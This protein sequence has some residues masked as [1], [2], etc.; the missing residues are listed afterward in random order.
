MTIADIRSAVTVVKTLVL[1]NITTSLPDWY[2]T[3]Q[4]QT[5][6]T[7]LKRFFDLSDS[8]VFYPVKSEKMTFLL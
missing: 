1:T 3:R 7:P 4:I 5:L 6:E 2:N 8:K